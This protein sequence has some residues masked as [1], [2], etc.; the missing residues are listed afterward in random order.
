LR[1]AAS[2]ELIVQRRLENPFGQ[3]RLNTGAQ[4]M[5]HES[6]PEEAQL[7]APTLSS[8]A[9]RLPTDIWPGKPF[10][11]QNCAYVAPFCVQAGAQA[12]VIALSR[13]LGARR[14]TARDTF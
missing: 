12:A 14:T 11:N 3:R 7:T 4:S 9:A 2:I 5:C 10:A 13:A 1:K 6:G 8:W